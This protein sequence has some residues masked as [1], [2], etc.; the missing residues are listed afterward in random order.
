VHGPLVLRAQREVVL[1]DDWK[2]VDVCA[3]RHT[4]TGGAAA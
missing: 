3:Q 2:C 1:L 4:G